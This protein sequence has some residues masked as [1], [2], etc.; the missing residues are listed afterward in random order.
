MANLVLKNGTI[1]EMTP[2]QSHKISM[3]ILLKTDW[4]KEKVLVNGV[5]FALGDI[6]QDPAEIA[7]VTQIPM[8]P[9]GDLQLKNSQNMG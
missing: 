6:L 5:R 8:W 7:R 2:E 3:M 4:E 1:V 9:D